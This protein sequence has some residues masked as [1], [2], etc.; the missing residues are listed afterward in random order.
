MTICVSV[1]TSQG[2]VLGTDS[3]STIT[4]Q[5]D[6]Q[7]GVVKTYSNARKLVQMGNL[8]IG[9]FTYGLGNLGARSIHGLIQEYSQQRLVTMDVQ[10]IAMGLA[11]HIEP[12]YRNYVGSESGG[13]T[14]GL[15]VAG[16]S[17]DSPLP[18]EW[19]IELPSSPT[20]RLVQGSDEFGV[21]WRGIDRPFLRLYRGYDMRLFR[22]LGQ[23]IIARGVSREMLQILID[24]ISDVMQEIPLQSKVNFQHMPIQDAINFAVYVLRTTIGYTTFESGPPSCGGPLQIAAIV[25]GSGFQWISEPQYRIEEDAHERS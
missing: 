13:T 17:E 10:S 3:M 25:E 16:Y 4:H 19:G 6:G 7:I 8:P 11:K 12:I 18:E 1:K 9:V 2:I 5:V 23:N 15:Y 21:T 14:L 20:P 22:Q 24:S